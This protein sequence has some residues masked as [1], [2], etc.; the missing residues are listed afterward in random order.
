MKNLTIFVLLTLLGF[1]LGKI[2]EVNPIAFEHFNI[3]ASIALAFGLYTAVSG[4][5]LSSLGKYKRTAIFI[6]TAG[7]PI[8]IFATAAIMYMIYPSPLSI[9]VAVSID[10]IDPLSVSTLLNNKLGM[11]KSAKS[12]LNIWASFD[13][14]VTVLFGFAL[15]LPLVTKAS[16]SS[17]EDIFVGIVINV[18]PAITIYFIYGK[19]LLK[20]KYIQLALL[21]LAFIFT[22]T[23]QSFLLIALLGLFIKPFTT[24]TL[25]KYTTMIYY[26][27]SILVGMSLPFYGVDLRLGFI[28][29]II[30]F[31][32]VQP[33]SAIIMVKGTANDILRLAFAQQNGLTTL[34]MGLTFQVLGFNVLPILLPAIVFI[35]F[36]NL[37]VNGIYSHIR[38]YCYVL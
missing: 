16:F 38:N 8:Q 7:V 17:L 35:N 36:F 10:Q 12:L 18:L 5:D 27:I 2:F 37:L 23:T 33:I 32:I 1:F 19:G 29:A 13:D 3:G 11:S 25:R 34:L 6:I 24:H 15:L 30:E 26:V 28:L 22:V 14:P 20:S 31:F 4:I 9:L 21:L